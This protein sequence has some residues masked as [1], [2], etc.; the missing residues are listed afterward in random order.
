[1]TK[2]AVTLPHFDFFPG[3]KGELA[4]KYP[5]TRFARSGPMM[6]GAELI[7]FVKGCDTAVIGLNRFTEDVCAALPELK[8]VSMCSAGVDHIDPAVL[9]KHGIRIWWVPGINKVSV[10]E[11]AVCYMVFA[12]RRLQLFS[13]VLAR[14]EWKGPMGFGGDLRGRTVGIHGV[15]HIGKE[16]VKLLQPYGVRI[17]ACDRVDF[18]DFYRQ[19]D[20]VEKV[21]AEALWARSD[22]LTIHLSRNRTTIGMYSGAVLA[23]LKPG[24]MLVNCAR[25]GIVDEEALAERLK[26]GAIAGAAFDVFCVEPANGNPLLKLQN[27]FGSPHIGATT[28]ESWEAMLRSG[29]HGIEHAYEPEPGVYPFD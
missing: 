26:S 28:L 18:S 22:V 7:E 27:F 29:M 13:S 20:N 21:D 1:M 3:L 4:A 2:L 16:V 5:G 6:Q 17:L 14:G 25:G 11:L 8:V 23:K 10:S 24:M 9:T 19:F 15:G 12:L